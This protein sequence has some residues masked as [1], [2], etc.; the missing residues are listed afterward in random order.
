MRDIMIKKIF[1]DGINKVLVK[2]GRLANFLIK[3]GYNIINIAPNKKIQNAS[4]F[5]F[6]ADDNIDDCILEYLTDM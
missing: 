2:D 3:K 5:Y 1:S 6:V 4:V